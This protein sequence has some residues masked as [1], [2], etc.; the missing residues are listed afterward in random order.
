MT[1][2]TLNAT[3]V[4]S[5]LT[6]VGTIATGVWN[7]TDVAL[8][9]GGTNASLTAVNGGVVYSTA[10]AMAISAAGTSG[11]IL[12]S[13]G[14]SAPTWATLDMSYLP[15]AALKKSVKAATTAD[16]A[17]ASATTTTITGTNVVFPTQDGITI[18]LNDRILVKDQTL[19]QNNG[20][21]YLSQQGVVA[22]T[23]WILTRVTDADTIT[24]IA[25]AL[26]AVDS[27]TTYGGKLFDNDLK[28][29]DTL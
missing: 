11:Q 8:G 19:S 29:T 14:A 4:T 6:S 21:Y 28:T 20:I 1:G 17:A 18:A 7:G 3:V 12:R 2:T 25:S 16:L 5:S 13:N 23:P 22:T 15:D 26:V 10:S 27:G 24:E 9:A